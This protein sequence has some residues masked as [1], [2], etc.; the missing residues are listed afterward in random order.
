M[1]SCIFGYTKQGAPV[2]A[3]TLTNTQGAECV[4]LDYGCTVQALKVP[5][6]KN[7]F[8]DVVLGYDSVSEYEE[9]DGYFGAAIGRM[10]NRVGASVFTLGG[11]SYPLAANDGVNHLHG[12]IKGFDKYI[13]TAEPSGNNT[14]RFSRV[15]PDGEE[16]YPG[17]LFVSVSYTLTD[18][19]ALV[20]RYDADTDADTV[21]S[22]TNHSYFNLNGSG[23]A[24]NHI[25]QIFADRFTENDA[26]CLPTGK[27]LD[28]A[29][30]PF[31]FAAPK[32][33]GRDIDENDEQLACGHGYDHNYVLS[34]AEGLKK[35]AVLFS[36]DSG[37][38]LTVS[39]TLPGMQLYS[40]NWLSPRKG[41]LGAQIS[42][43]GA[44]CL[45]TQLFPN[46]LACPDFPSPILRAGEHYH[47]ET[48]YQF[49]IGSEN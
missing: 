21:I 46:A 28:V 14:L 48:V 42:P 20:I 38:R 6:E 40:A 32:A 4:L 11:K 36:P 13:W 1:K 2:T 19:N 35:A 41:K 29:G 47:S 17:T 45:E 7:A 26:A 34:G 23:S 49:E 39:T 43:R 27:F 25:L 33:L 24:L 3:Y 30:G 16:G 44:V 8:I 22:L 10:A 15:S 9:H 12:G 18:E 5:D 31:D 37:I